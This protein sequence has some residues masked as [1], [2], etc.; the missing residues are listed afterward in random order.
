MHKAIYIEGIITLV[1]NS[2]YTFNFAGIAKKLVEEVAKVFYDKYIVTFEP[3]IN[4][5]LIL[6]STLSGL[7]SRS[8]VFLDPW[9][10]S[11]SKK[12]QEPEPQKIC[13]SCMRLLR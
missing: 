11:R 4:L 6:F 10:R 3:Y 2:V 12:T 13:Y 1:L 9:S 5:Y 7:G 8:R